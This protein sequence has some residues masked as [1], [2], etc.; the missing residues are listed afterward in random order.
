MMP[1]SGAFYLLKRLSRKILYFL[2][3]R[4]ATEQLSVYWHRAFLLDHMA[5]KG[6]FQGRP[7]DLENA[8]AALEQTLE[9]CETSPLMQLARTTVRGAHRVMRLLIRARRQG[10][11]AQVRAQEKVLENHWA[12]VSVHFDAVAA[13]YDAAL[14]VLVR[15]KDSSEDKVDVHRSGMSLNREDAKHAKKEHKPI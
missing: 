4:E 14:S 10:D 3:I 8:R 7:K 6:L 2:T 9:E 13:A 11:D 5:C 12:D 15:I 1:L